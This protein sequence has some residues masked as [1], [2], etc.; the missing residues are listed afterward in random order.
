MTDKS[1]AIIDVLKECQNGNLISTLATACDLSETHCL[2][3]LER[4]TPDIARR[5]G[6]RISDE[7]D[8]EDL[9]D[10]LDEEDQ[11]EIL[12]DR[13]ALF[14]S[15]AAEDGEDILK[16]LYGSMDQA[17]SQARKIGAPEGVET[18]VFERLMTLAAALTFSAMARRNQMYQMSALGEH[19][20]QSSGGDGLMARLW[21]AMVTGFIEGFTQATRRKRR[22][23]RKRSV[24]EQIFG[25]KK[26][27]RRRSSRRRKT[28]R[29]RKTP[30]IQDLLGDIFD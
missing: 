16:L 25:T 20:Q 2:T 18:D 28:R 12:D 30:S 5:I 7:D 17:R 27:T 26:T 29:K 24:L 21:N 10:V 22:R 8:Y 14:D 3:S 11:V 6:E 13:D 1:N 4:L 15:D 9:L 19:D 23:R